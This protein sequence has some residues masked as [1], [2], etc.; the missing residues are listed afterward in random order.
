MSFKIG[1]VS[2]GCAKN[3][4]NTEQMMYLLTEAGYEVTSET[5]DV[6]AVLVNTCGF[7]E[8]AKME[9][10]DTIIELGKLKEEGRIKKLIV[11]GCLAERYKDEIL[12]Q[13]PE[14]DAVVGVGSFDEIVA[15]VK[16]ALADI[17]NA[18]E[19]DIASEIEN[20][21][22]ND[23]TQKTKQIQSQTQAKAQYFG[24]INA[25]LSETKRVITTS[26]A[27]TYLKIAD[28]C[29]NHCAYCAIPSIRGRFRSRH[30]E[31]IIDEAK[32]LAQKGIKELIIV[33]QDVTR[34]GRDLYGKAMLATLLRELC[35][36]ES[37]KWIRLHYLY[38]DEISDELI[39][40]I[41]EN[42]IIVK[43]LD[44]PIQHI[45]DE[46]LKNMGRRGTGDEIKSLISHLRERIPG[47][48][49]RTSIIAGLPGENDEQFDELGQFLKEAKI[50]RTGIF[51]YSPEE[52]TPAADMDRPEQ[53][54]AEHRAKV[55]GDIQSIVIDDYNAARIGTTTEVL[56][57]SM[58]DEGYIGRSYAESPEIDGYIHIDGD[59]INIDEF[60]SVLIT[61]TR[62]GELFGVRVLDEYSE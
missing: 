56:I 30:M 20:A 45:N 31:N 4:I 33:A 52:G 5:E 26:T 55:L 18:T 38:P 34:Y 61:D 7:I 32:D 50:Q 62:D 29:D 41:A 13:M 8:S 60:V 49:L 42:D 46:I 6:A 9:A 28:G 22:G 54:M 2:L 27:W 15:A 21:S 40:V 14:I 58:T 43:Y 47:L 39:E 57:E 59:G 1:I 36:I 19:I 10:I 11:A 44:I 16:G 53:Y 3:L 12:S 35:T 25:K 17:E 37:I 51:T 23:S 48:V 24:D